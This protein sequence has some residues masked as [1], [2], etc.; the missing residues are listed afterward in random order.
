MIKEISIIEPNSARLVARMGAPDMM[1]EVAND[2][3][4]K[5]YRDALEHGLKACGVRPVNIGMWNAGC[6][7][8]FVACWGWRRGQRLRDAGHEVLVLER[9]YIGDRFA[10]T[11]LGWNGLNGHAQFPA[12]P[13]DF[14]A[15]F[16]EMGK[17]QPWS[18][19][20]SGSR[21]LILGQVPGDASL[22][23]RDMMPWYEEM[24][25]KAAARYP[26][27]PIYFRPHPKAVEKNIHREV[28]GA[29]TCQART[30]DQALATAAFTIC[31]NSNSSVDSI[32][33]GI[34]CI[35]GDRGSMAWE[36][37]AHDFPAP[38]VEWPR[39]DREKWAHSLA[40]RQ[41]RIDEI[42]SG[43]ALRGVLEMVA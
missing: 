4:P 22:Q 17:L 13:E 35:V 27:L 36:M 42:I 24:A 18:A 11:S 3:S 14:G 31:F 26:S 16:K 28:R 33:A 19:P 9:G 20:G 40:W 6:I 10:Y 21:I 8:K 34:P 2:V 29:I 15:R 25:A 37:C 41:W 30:L 39:P 32:L 1:P 38:A 12:A 43:A 7:T 5:T 23:G